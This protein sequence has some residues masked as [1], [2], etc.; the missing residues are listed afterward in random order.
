MVANFVETLDGVVAIPDV[1]RSNALI[2]AE[3]DA[4]RF[5][6][7]LLR[8]CADAILV[9]SGTLLASPQG[10]WRPERAYP[11]AAEDLLELR[12][13]RG[14]PEQPRVAVVS[15]GATLDVSHP[16]LARGALVLTTATAEADLR[17][18]VPS[19][20]EVIA[21]NEGDSVDLARALE[22]LRERGYGVVLSEGGP[23]VLAS[24]LASRLVDELFLTLSPLVAGRAPGGVRL[25]LVEGV[26]LLPDVRIEG[27]LR[28]ARR[29]GAHLLLRYGLS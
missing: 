4:D 15:T 1:P 2:A 12:R 11:P 6:M 3:S 24:L 20:A 8:A 17:A 16:V 18:T 27:E 9:G 10:A 22:L 28:S 19:E 21:V 7:A 14:L 5:V 29:S 26:E 25:S 23:T 13:L